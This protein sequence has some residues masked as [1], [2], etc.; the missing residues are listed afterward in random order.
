LVRPDIPAIPKP[1]GGGESMM[2][3]QLNSLLGALLLAV[4][5][6]MQQA[7]CTNA[8][9]Y[10]VQHRMPQDLKAAL[11]GILLTPHRASSVAGAVEVHLEPGLDRLVVCGPDEALASAARLVA[12]LDVKAAEPGKVYVYFLEH[13]NAAAAAAWLYS[14][15]PELRGAMLAEPIPNTLILHAAPADWQSIR[16][17]LL[18]LDRRR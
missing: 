15:R 11:E 10:Q 7:P 3:L 4:L 6:S 14:S 5:P 16:A 13:V 12:F 1:D 17:A 8:R 9:T 2:P 18:A